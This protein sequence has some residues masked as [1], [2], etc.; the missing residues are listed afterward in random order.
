MDVAPFAMVAVRTVAGEFWVTAIRRN[1][2]LDR[3]ESFEALNAAGTSE[4]FYP[5][6]IVPNIATLDRDYAE[7]AYWEDYCGGCD[8]SPCP[9]NGHCTD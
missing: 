5:C 9:E 3:L 8:R 4:V 6:D 7:E 1:Y 2:N